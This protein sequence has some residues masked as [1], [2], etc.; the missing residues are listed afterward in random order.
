MSTPKR[1]RPARWIAAAALGLVVAGATLA[2]L[3]RVARLESALGSGPGVCQDWGNN[4]PGGGK[5]AR[6]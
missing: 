5:K 4:A 6:G 3:A 2:D 1:A